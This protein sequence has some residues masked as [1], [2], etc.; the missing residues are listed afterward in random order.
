MATRAL[1]KEQLA[2]LKEL[3]RDFYAD[4]I[5]EILSGLERG[6][7]VSIYANTDYDKEQMQVIRLGL[8]AGLDVSFY[9][10]PKFSFG[11]MTQIYLGLKAGV[12]VSVYADPKNGTYLMGDIR[13]RLEANAKRSGGKK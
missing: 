8:E 12:D 1:S 10:D 11:Q 9:A 3:L 2:Q 5:R 7:D 6:V 4:E 13:E